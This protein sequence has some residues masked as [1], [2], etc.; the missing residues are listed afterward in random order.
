MSKEFLVGNGVKITESED[1]GIFIHF[2]SKS[3]NSSGYFL[4]N[5][6]ETPGHL[7]ASEILEGVKGTTDALEA[8][9]KE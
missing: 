2:M 1:M 7:W 9:S 8:N 4:G 6:K 3:G 5:T